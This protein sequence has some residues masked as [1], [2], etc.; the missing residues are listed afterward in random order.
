MLHVQRHGIEALPGDDFHRQGIGH[1]GPGRTQGFIGR[2]PSFQGHF[3]FSLSNRF[4]FHPEIAGKAKKN[5]PQK[6]DGD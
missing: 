1:A 3:C 6:A 5:R 2:E 4:Q